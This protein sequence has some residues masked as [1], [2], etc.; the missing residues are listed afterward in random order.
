MAVELMQGGCSGC[1]RSVWR[2]I[3]KV[4]R[5]DICRCDGVGWGKGLELYNKCGYLWYNVLYGWKNKIEIVG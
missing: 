3:G 4:L 1:T 5:D 2:K